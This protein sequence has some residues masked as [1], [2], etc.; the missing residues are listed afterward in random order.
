MMFGAEAGDAES[1]YCDKWKDHPGADGR[2]PLQ[3]FGRRFVCS[4]I[5][6]Y[7]TIVYYCILFYMIGMFIRGSPY[8]IS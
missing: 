7:W 3:P 8:K 2:G 6:Y 4:N 1:A 5:V